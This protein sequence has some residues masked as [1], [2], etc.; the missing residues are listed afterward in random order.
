MILA[1]AWQQERSIVSVLTHYADS[2][3]LV[4]AHSGMVTKVGFLLGL[5][6]IK[7]KQ[8]HFPKYKPCPTSDTYTQVALRQ[9]TIVET[10][11]NQS[12]QHA[13]VKFNY[14]SPYK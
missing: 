4:N 5:S 3:A 13:V 8:V 10:E 2:K 11:L 9:L 1:K 7:A 12:I 14:Y 6:L